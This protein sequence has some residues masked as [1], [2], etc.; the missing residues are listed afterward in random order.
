M[1][2]LSLVAAV[3]VAVITAVAVAVLVVCSPVA[4]LLLRKLIRL[5]SVAA[6]MEAAILL[7]LAHGDQMA[8]ILLL[9]VLLQL[10]AA[11]EALVREEDRLHIVALAIMAALAAVALDTMAV[12]R[13]VEIRLEPVQAVK[14]TQADMAITLQQLMVPVAAA[15]QAQ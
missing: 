4:L 14:E 10:V 8:I 5:R 12:A 13:S 15:V 3:A 11:V 1:S 7:A 2:T 9:A 6:G